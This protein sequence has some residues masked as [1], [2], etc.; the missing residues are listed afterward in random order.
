MPQ[1]ELI[2]WIFNFFMIWSFLTI[3]FSILIN[4]PYSYNN[5]NFV[6]TN[7]ITPHNNN[8]WFWI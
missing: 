7:T 6:S 5:T 4:T 2:N 1:L 8:N 3:V